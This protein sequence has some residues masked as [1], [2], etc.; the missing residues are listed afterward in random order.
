MQWQLQH[1][2]FYEASIRGHKGVVQ[3]LL[4]NGIC[5]NKRRPGHERFIT[6]LAGASAGGY[7]KVVKRLLRYDADRGQTINSADTKRATALFLASFEG[8]AKIARLLLD[9]GA[10]I[11]IQ[12]NGCKS[13]TSLSAASARRHEHVV[14]LLVD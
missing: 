5:P 11:D 14:R 10:D 6:A 8:H 13:S 1:A 3:I 4:E 7:T 12:N 9:N 2:A